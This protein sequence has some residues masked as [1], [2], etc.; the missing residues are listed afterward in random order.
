M[1][2]MDYHDALAALRA[3]QEA[4]PLSIIALAEPITAAQTQP[5]PQKHSCSQS[6]PSDTLST[7]ETE[8]N[9]QLTP[10]ALLADLTHYK[11][12]FSKLRFSYLE[13][14]TKEKYLR[15][16][17]GYPPLV[18][19]HED[20]LVLEE[21][22]EVMKKELK[23]KKEDVDAL[24]KG[25]EGR[26]RDVARAYDGVREGLDVLER[27]PV[28]IES[29]KAEVESLHAEIA[30]RQGDHGAHPGSVDPRMHLSLSATEQALL[31]QRE[32]NAEIDRQIAELQR[33][34]PAKVREVE[35]MD[36]ELAELEKR[37]NESAR[38]AV[39]GRRRREQGGRDEMEELG[40]WYR[41]N[42]AV[43]KG[44]LGVEERMTPDRETE[45]RKT[46]EV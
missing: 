43:M 15:S 9:L 42:E 8:S 1:G 39:E 37:R 12:L 3:Q 28:E 29:L 34:M 2:S 21:R 6:R 20:N 33:Q 13:Q 27:V 24:V 40:R 10:A 32:R 7:S 36:R 30:V 16:I 31:E 45:N 38:L 46:C 19:S 44:L 22:L 23:T 18:V 14:V 17:V 25:M 4:H 41:A 35:K 11:D 5:Q 26:A